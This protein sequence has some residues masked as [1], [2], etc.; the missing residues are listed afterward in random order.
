M[1]KSYRTNSKTARSPRRPF[2]KERLDQELK[3]IGEY[4]LK[5]KREVWRV[6]YV[7]AK[8]RTA[9]RN[10]LTLDEKDPERIFQGA[11]L[12]RRLIGLGLL[13]EHEQKLDYVLGLTINKMLER[14]LQTKV[15]KNGLSK[16]IHHSRVL[17]KQRHIR[18][19]RQIVDVPSYMVRLDSEKHIDFALTSPMGGGRPG[20][21]KRKSLKK[22]DGGAGDDDDDE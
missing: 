7:L 19:G 15:F 20:R 3:L 4:G 16:S 5:N 2:E 14:R 8:L 21:R 18:V 13:S 6:Q 10:L 11:A 17:I 9:A 22:G 12:L 1:G